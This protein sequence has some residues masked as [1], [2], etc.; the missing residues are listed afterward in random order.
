MSMDHINTMRKYVVSTAVHDP[1]WNNTTVID[2]DPIAA[3]TALKNQPGGDIVQY[4]FGHLAHELMEHG[5]LDELRLWIHPFFVGH[6]GPQDLIYRH[7]SMTRL[8]LAD[9]TPLSSGIVILSYRR[10]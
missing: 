6:G 8:E 1:Q 9:S 2:R 5:L 4:G 10:A 3:I 7:S